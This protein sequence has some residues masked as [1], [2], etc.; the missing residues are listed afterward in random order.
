[1]A[2]VAQLNVEIGARVA[3]LQKGLKAA[4]RDLRQSG[5]RMARIGAD[6]TTSLSI[7][8]GLAGAAAISAAGD[9]ES[10]TLALKSQLGTAEAASNELALLT[11][12]AKN[13][14]L[15]L[16]QAVRGSVRLQGVAFSAEEARNVL[17]QMG[18]AIAATGGSAQELDNVTRQ[19]A[20]MTSKGRVLQED[21]SILSENMPGLAQLM[22]KAFGTQSVEAIRA[23]GVSGKEFVLQI[24]KAAEALPR[25]EGGIKNSIGNALDSLKQSVAKVGFA[26]N[27]AFNVTGAIET[28]ADFALRLAEGFSSLNPVLQTTILSIAGVAI[29]AGPLIS[30]FGAIKGLGGQIVAL[31][32]SLVS[33]FRFLAGA[34][35]NGVSAFQALNT[36]MKVTVIGAALAAI[37]ALYFAY[38]SYTNSL[39][40][41][42]AAQKSVND[43]TKAAISSTEVERAKISNLVSVLED[44]TQSLDHKRNALNGLKAIA[45]SYFNDLDIEDGKVRGLTQAVDAYVR[46]LERSAIVKQATDE[47]A[48][49]SDILRNIGDN[50]AATT[51]QQT[52]NAV[53][54]LGQSMLFGNLAGAGFSETFDN[55]NKNTQT[56]NQID[57]QASTQAKIDSLRALIKENIDLG[58][59][60]AKTTDNTKKY[61]GAV[62]D[63]S[64]KAR[65]LKEVLSDVSNATETARLLGE[66]EDVAKLEELQKGI[67]KL[68]DAGFKPASAEV[69]NLKAQ[70]DALTAKPK[71]IVINVIRTG[72]GISPV[73]SENAPAGLPSAPVAPGQSA[74]IA[75]AEEE[76]KRREQLAQEWKDTYLNITTQAVS[77]AAQIFDNATNAKRDK[78]LAQLEA[79]G[80]VRLANAKGNAALEASIQADLDKKRAAI[81]KKASIRKKL[82]ALG[83]AAI[84]IAVGV[85]KAIASAP[86]PLN[87]P[88]IIATAAQGAIQL[89]VI[90]S[91]KFAAGTRDAPGGLA[92][93]GERGPELVNLPRH[94]QVFNAGVTSTALRGGQNLN[95]T[96]EFVARGTEMV[97]VIDRTRAKEN[98]F[99]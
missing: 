41:A 15:G 93:V 21:V 40:A 5:A 60:T 49:Q 50:G 4:E 11:E 18:N 68:I 59:E 9:I 39:T 74:I 35:L 48:K 84:N 24:T 62:A 32:S 97:L 73:S 87:I 19:F 88:A 12:A 56:F 2:T 3:E 57:L 99:K 75:Q 77:G 89:G 55:L 94:S 65:V 63:T 51:L 78:D 83:E 90:A 61:G 34:V 95:I 47:L 91:Q 45:P 70:L 10:L 92:L 13:P 66:D 1:M 82:A 38:D 33:G 6:I 69:Q 46:S 54:A 37:T 26:I 64:A 43:V 44:N 27:N 8:L 17:V 98:R 16:E 58:N 53:L 29:A 31:S 20:Q 81:E 28:F 30:A 7:P 71:D 36:A 14:G 72:G 23:M 96:G 85:T 76:N 80:K 52:G 25:V 42:E 67:K 86:P 22:Q 79:E